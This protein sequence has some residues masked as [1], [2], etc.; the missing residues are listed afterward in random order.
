MM[1]IDGCRLEYPRAMYISLFVTGDAGS[2]SEVR[3]ELEVGLGNEVA[4]RA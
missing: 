1:P 2:R 4:M 3:L